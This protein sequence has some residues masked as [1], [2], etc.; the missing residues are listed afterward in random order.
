MVR[1][2]VN[3]QEAIKEELNVDELETDGDELFDG[4]ESVSSD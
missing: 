1:K 2:E 4:L 3:K